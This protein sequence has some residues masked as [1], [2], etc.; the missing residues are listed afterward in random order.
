MKDKRINR[1]Q[2]SKESGIP[3]TT[4][5]GFYKKGT[6]NVKL[7]TLKKLSNYFHVPLDY[8]NDEEIKKNIPKEPAL[9]LDEL[10]TDFY[11]DV[12]MGGSET[13]K[14]LL[15]RLEIGS[16]VLVDEDWAYLLRTVDLVLQERENKKKAEDQNTHI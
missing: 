15:A 16:S 1:S 8:W 12:I 2:L 6:D 14:K 13:Q 10:A 4:I 9:T 5:D 11:L 3:Y 7:S